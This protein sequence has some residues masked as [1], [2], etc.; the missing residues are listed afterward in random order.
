MA[1]T[2]PNPARGA[3]GSAEVLCKQNA[4]EN[5]AAA[6]ADQALKFH[7]LA[8]IFPLM[9]GAEFE[10][11]VADIK[12]NGCR[13]PIYL[14]EGMILDGRN[15]YRACLVAGVKLPC[16]LR[17]ASDP[18]DFDPVAFV[19]SHNIHRRH[20][21]AEQRRE[22]IAKL[23]T[24]QPEK[25]NRQ[26]AKT[27]GVSH[28]HVAKV[29]GDLERSGDVETVTTSIDTKGRKQPAKKTKRRGAKPADPPEAADA[30]ASG[31][32]QMAAHAR[33]TE[34]EATCE[35]DLDLAEQLQAAKIKIAGLESEI[36]ELKAEN[37]KLRAKLEAAGASS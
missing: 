3:R 10:A 30:I 6:S 12:A 34:L 11:L 22:L 4:D 20:L 8:D 14:H 17:L 25:S 33:A 35:H 26:I 16:L 23:I 7:P 36:E 18:T 31:I 9:E 5:K 2:K 28:P 24:A 15:R 32:D 37:A 21:T 1:H 19:I 29:R 13:E 27:A